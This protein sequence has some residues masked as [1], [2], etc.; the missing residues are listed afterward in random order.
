VGGVD[1]ADPGS[2]VKVCI[3]D[4]HPVVVE[5]VRTWLAQDSRIVV[6]HTGDDLADVS[7][8]AADVLILDLNL[9][10]KLM[11]EEIATLAGAGQRIIA[12][13]Q[14]TGEDVILAVLDGG[15]CAFVSKNEGRE[16]LLDTVAAVAA[17]RPYVTP[18]T[19][20]VMV[21]DRRPEAP[22]LSEQERTALLW[23][24]QSMSKASAARRM[25]ISTHTV[26]MYI[27]RARLKYAQVGRPA[28]TKADMLLR[29]IED[30]IVR[31]DE[32][33]VYRSAAA[34]MRPAP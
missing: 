30:E 25:A 22:R 29:A 31:P 21:G 6:V 12:F 11:I 18:A 19:A 17:D 5:G 14:F 10:G 34:A 3:I 9:H 8:I 28:P 15:A 24:F 7:G 26:D 27:R 23:W 16:H 13:S 20:G 1:L 4:D 33:A 2:S 32:I